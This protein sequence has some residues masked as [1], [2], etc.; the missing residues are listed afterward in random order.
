MGTAAIIKIE[1]K[2]TI[3]YEDG[4]L[5]WAGN[6]SG[7][8]YGRINTGEPEQLVHRI[9]FQA[10]VR[11]LL[12]DEQIDHE[13]HNKAAHEGLCAGGVSCLH[14]RCLNPKHLRAVTVAENLGASPFTGQGRRLSLRL[15]AS[16]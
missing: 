2:P 13:C 9:V 16:G 3:P 10:R 6:I 8:G 11:A 1:A 12:P 7:Y 14:R 5:L 4:C 15:T